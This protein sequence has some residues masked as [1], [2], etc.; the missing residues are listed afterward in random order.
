M[1]FH[2]SRTDPLLPALALLHA[3]HDAAMRAD[4]PPCSNHMLAPQAL[5]AADVRFFVLWEGAEP[6]GMA[7]L[8]SAKGYGEI[9]S[10]H[11]LTEARGRGYAVALL[12]HLIAEAQ[13]LGQLF[14]ETGA[15]ESFAPSRALYL[16]EGFE[17]CGP[18]GGYA[19]DP[20]S[21]FMRRAV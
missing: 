20:L 12:R 19:P 4:T 2:I 18:F 14:L 17:I 8:K 10:M 15:Q 21:V 16:R 13:G 7:A 5:A 3:R 1:S 11:V 6:M 9:K